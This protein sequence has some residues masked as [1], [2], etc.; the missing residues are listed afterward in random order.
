IESQNSKADKKQL[1]V[2]YG[3]VKPGPLRIL[4][5]DRYIQTPQDVYYS[6]AGKACIFL[7]VIFNVFN[8]NDENAFLK[9]WKDV[10]KSTNWYRMP[11]P[12]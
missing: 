9:H 8:L 4:N 10:E 11:N 1:A 2:K 7:E 3:L 5:W 6:L 12:L